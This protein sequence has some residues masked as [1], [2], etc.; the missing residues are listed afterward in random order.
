LSTSAVPSSF[1]AYFLAAINPGVLMSSILA[2]E[3]EEAISSFTAVNFP[4]WGTYLIFYL[5]V[6][7]LALFIAIKNLRVNMKRHK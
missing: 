4:L 1:P 5:S 7:I 6:T 3:I 2:P